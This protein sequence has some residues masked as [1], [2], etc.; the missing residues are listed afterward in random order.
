MNHGW[1]QRGATSFTAVAV[2]AWF[3][4]D[5]AEVD[6]GSTIRLSLSVQNLGESTES[7]TIV[8]SGLTADWVTVE[9]GNLSLFGGSGDVVDVVVAPPELPTTSAG[10]T[11]IGVRIIPTDVPDDTTSAETTIDVRPFDDRRVVALQPVVRA[12]RRASYEFMVENHGNGLASCRLRLVD[13]TERIDGSFDPPAVGVAPG[14]ASLVRLKAK[15]RRGS[16]RRTPRALDFEVEAEQPN[17]DPAAAELT[18]L[19]P[20]TIPTGL[21]SRLAT[22]ALVAGAL[23]L[24]WFA[25]V[26]PTVLDAIEDRV[27]ERLVEFEA[28]AS[29]MADDGDEPTASVPVD[30]PAPADELGEPFFRRLTVTPPPEGSADAALTVPDDSALDVTDV[31]IE[32]SNGDSGTATLSVNGDTLFVWSLDDVRGS[33][34]EPTITQK[35]LVAGDN[36]TLSVRCQAPG[37][38][39]SGACLTAVNVGGRL[40]D[41]ADL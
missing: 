32:N 21:L 19:Q 36:V 1:R 17:H 31:R 13:P 11:G 23:A 9:R 15:A 27:D 8:P 14:G 30:E 7:Y 4:S 40:I 18:L 5:D 20:T 6:P 28:V 16:L 26:R 33:T 3:S 39:G 34:F 29:D 25:V 10:P 37:D 22:L 35:R 41:A 24:A 38:Q 12:R 2:Q